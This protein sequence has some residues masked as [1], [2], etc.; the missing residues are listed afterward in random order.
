MTVEE[1]YLRR[2]KLILKYPNHPCIIENKNNEKFF[3]P[4]ETLR[5]YILHIEPEDTL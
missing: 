2:Y 3:Y 1:Y 4:L 5:E